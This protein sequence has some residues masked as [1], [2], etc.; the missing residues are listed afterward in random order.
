MLLSYFSL[1]LYSLLLVKFVLGTVRLLACAHCPV[2]SWTSDL[3]GYKMFP[4][5]YRHR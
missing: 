2:T 4:F 3:T 1:Y 5:Y